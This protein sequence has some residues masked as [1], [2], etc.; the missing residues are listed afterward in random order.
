MSRINW[1]VSFDQI[2]FSLVELADQARQLEPTNNLESFVLAMVGTIC[3][4]VSVRLG[5]I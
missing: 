4:S 3:I 1:H 5:D 2:V